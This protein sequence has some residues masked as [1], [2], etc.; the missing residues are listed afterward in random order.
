MLAEREAAK[1]PFLRAGLNL[2]EG[3]DLQLDE[4]AGPAYSKRSEE[5]TSELQSR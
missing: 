2:L 5:H 4:L 3:L 1:Y